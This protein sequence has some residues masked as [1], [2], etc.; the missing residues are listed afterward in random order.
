MK[1]SWK[2]IGFAAGFAALLASGCAT[3]HKHPSAEG[4]GI[5][6]PH[7]SHARE[8][9]GVEIVS[10]RPTLAGR[11][12]DFRF[13]VVDPEKAIPVL[14]RQNRAY[15]VDETTGV[16][17]EVPFTKVGSMR[18][19]TPSPE[20]G[21]VYYMLFNAAGRRVSPG[22]KF[23]VVVGNHRFENL[24]VQQGRGDHHETRTH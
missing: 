21:R 10:L 15:L 6:A 11:L 4:S 14:N 1:R 8:D 9:S 12:M 16:R 5:P 13:R 24:T 3:A 7:A 22:D 18:Q 20:K 19:T 23:T 17:M 2:R